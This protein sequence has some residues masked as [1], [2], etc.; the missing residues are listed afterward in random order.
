MAE[1]GGSR[2][3]GKARVGG[4]ARGYSWP[5][6][7]PGNQLAVKHGAYSLLQLKPRAAELADGLWDLLAG[8][9]QIP[10]M[11]PAVESAG[12]V[13]ARFEAAMAA[14]LEAGDAADLRRLDQDAR[15]WARLWF[16]CLGMLGLTPESAVALGMQ[17][18]ITKGARLRAHLDE[19]Y[20]ERGDE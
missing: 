5:P 10:R 16:R 14:L 13:G 17:V 20:G 2:R 3:S 18:E 11:R 7:E 12:M 4:P 9:V 1:D 19:R 8:E 6:A 15:G